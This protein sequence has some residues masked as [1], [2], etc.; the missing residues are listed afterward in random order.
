M[1]N[2]F[3]SNREIRKNRIYYWFSRQFQESDIIDGCDNENK[4][5][6]DTISSKRDNRKFWV[7]IREPDEDDLDEEEFE[8]KFDKKLD[9]IQNF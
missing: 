3:E 6:N 9:Y 2:H 1:A 5:N 8:L 7:K 4:V